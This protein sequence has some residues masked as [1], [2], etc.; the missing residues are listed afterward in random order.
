MSE[1]YFLMIHFYRSMSTEVKQLK[2]PLRH[3]NLRENM[4]RFGQ[5]SKDSLKFL[6][7]LFYNP[8]VT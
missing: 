2:V 1:R 4:D 8:E 7:L 5:F 3:N 6:S